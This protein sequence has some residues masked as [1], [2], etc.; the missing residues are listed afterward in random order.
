[1]KDLLIFFLCVML[2]FPSLALAQAKKYFTIGITQWDA[3]ACYDHNIVGFK[4]GLAEKGY[5]E[6]K[7]VR[8]ILRNPRAN[9]DNQV[10]TVQFFVDQHVDLI[11]SLTTPGTLVAKGVTSKIPIVFS[12]V[13]YPVETGIVRSLISSDNNLT[14]TT[15]YVAPSRQY[16]YFEKIYPNTK[17]LAFIHRKGEP[18]SEFQ[19]KEFKEY[20]DKRKVYLMD[21]AAI[22]LNDI[23]EKLKANGEKID[24]LYGACDTLVQTGGADVINEFSHE[25]KKPSFSCAKEGVEKGAL[26][27]NVKDFYA[28]GRA[29]GEKAALALDGIPPSKIQVESAVED[30]LIINTKT[31]NEL[32]LIVPP[33]LLGKAKE[34][35]DH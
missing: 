28:I 4:E 9:V 14:G 7:N 30:E 3:N 34:I 27:G 11:Y 8:F 23:R 16:F 5:L 2:I 26:M 15:N 22:D 13:T 35:I 10:E 17:T 1:M 12:V 21:I 20:L 33:D 18:N 32:G 25:F 29:A 31:A 19:Y 24:A 6:G